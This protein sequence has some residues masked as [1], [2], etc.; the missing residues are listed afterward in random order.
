MA[1]LTMRD[2]RKLADMYANESS[3]LE[4]ASEIGCHP[5][6]IYEELKRGSTG[7]LDSNLRQA[8]DPELAQRR[9]QE[10]IRRCGRKKRIIA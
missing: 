4:I 5:Q 7:K 8:Y 6:T 1:R 3:V 2:R 9:V 10:N